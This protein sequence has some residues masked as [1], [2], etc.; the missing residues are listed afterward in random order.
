[1]VFIIG[2]LVGNIVTKTVRKYFESH[3]A[4]KKSP[5]VGSGDKMDSSPLILDTYNIEACSGDEMVNCKTKGKVSKMKITEHNS[6]PSVPKQKTTLDLQPI[7][8]EKHIGLKEHSH[9]GMSTDWPETTGFEIE[10]STSIKSNTNEHTAENKQSSYF[11]PDVP[12]ETNYLYRQKQS[13]VISNFELMKD[14]AMFCGAFAEIE[15]QFS[16]DLNDN[17]QKESCPEKT[18]ND[19]EIKESG[20]EASS[21]MIHDQQNNQKIMDNKPDTY[22]KPAEIKMDNNGYVHLE[23][24]SQHEVETVSLYQLTLDICKFSNCL[25]NCWMNAAMQSLLNLSIT[26]KKLAQDYNDVLETLPATPLYA[27]F[28]CTA[29]KNPGKIFYPPH[30]MP[31]LSEISQTVPSLAFGKQNET[32]V[33]LDFVLRWMAPCGINSTCVLCKGISCEDCGRT[34]HVKYELGPL[35]YLCDAKPNETTASLFHRSVIEDG[36]ENPCN[37]AKSE[38]KY[39]LNIPDVLALSV[40]RFTNDRD[41]RRQSIIPSTTIEV[42]LF[43]GTQLYRLSSIVCFVPHECNSNHFYTYIIHEQGN[44]KADDDKITVAGP[45]SRKDIEQN[46]LIY[47]YEKLTPDTDS[48]Q[49]LRD[50]EHCDENTKYSEFWTRISVLILFITYCV[51]GFLMLYISCHVII[52]FAMVLLSCCFFAS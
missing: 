52:Q 39:F 6:L 25:N 46:G 26:R 47:I 18:A 37:T 15:D 43:C 49:E 20:V 40:P 27:R 41:A 33:F 8:L 3:Y 44:I 2:L 45:N 13:Q 11:G 36:S 21:L 48:L 23:S 30:I 16:A 1:M 28:L 42:P 32:E 4:E 17:S 7:N 51:A 5:K 12:N 22:F 29:L 24:D 19:A 38:K 9:P 14:I 34:D 31:V 50:R 10:T 35:I